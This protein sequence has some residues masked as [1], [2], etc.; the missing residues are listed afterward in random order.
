MHILDVFGLLSPDFIRF[1]C[2][3]YQDFQF[4][5]NDVT[6]VSYRHHLLIRHHA[7]HVMCNVILLIKCCQKKT[8]FSVPATQLHCVYL[9]YTSPQYWPANSRDLNLVDYAVW[10]ILQEHVYHC[11]ICNVSRLKER[12][13]ENGITLIRASLIECSTSG[14]RHC[15]GVLERKEKRTLWASVLNAQTV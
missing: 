1:H 7:H 2:T 15:V 8:E 5:Q 3:V 4:V 11:W 13:I 10:R 14:G 12:L 9:R 6:N